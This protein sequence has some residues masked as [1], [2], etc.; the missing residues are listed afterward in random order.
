MQWTDPPSAADEPAFA[1]WCAYIDARL[2]AVR[3]QLTSAAPGDILPPDAAPE[4]PAPPVMEAGAG[5]PG[6]PDWCAAEMRQVA[7]IL[8]TT[9]SPVA[10]GY[11][12]DLRSAAGEY[13]Q[14]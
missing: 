4:R 1:A 8:L 9:D 2:A 7:D 12:N 3:D 6:F 11:A 10:L 14:K 5:H 13:H